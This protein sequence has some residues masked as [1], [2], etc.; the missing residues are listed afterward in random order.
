MPIT[1]FESGR[2]KKEKIEAPAVVNGFVVNDFDSLGEGKVLVRIPSLDE[3]VWA[4]IAS[5]GA[6]S[7]R[8]FFCSPQMGDEVLLVLSHNDPEDAYVIGGVWNATTRRPPILQPVDPL[9]KWIIRTG[10]IP[11]VG[12]QIELDDALQTI[13]ITTST[14]QII[15][16]SPAG[17]QIIS[18][19][20]TTITMTP[21]GI[22][23]LSGDNAI[24]L[25]SEG[26]TVSGKTIN[27]TAAGAV[28]I[29]GSVVNIN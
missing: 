16:M 6:G 23:V 9:V 27:L 20:K 15:K 1:I 19:P 12:H 5:I 18:D 3:T 22:Q 8:G 2:S 25:G 11:A 24:R 13:T 28:N 7:G 10:F 26:I 4:R 21:E 14:F 17:I 29:K